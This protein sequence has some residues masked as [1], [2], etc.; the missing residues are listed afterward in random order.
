MYIVYLQCKK[1][2]SLKKNI[3]IEYNKIGARITF[4]SQTLTCLVN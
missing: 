3:F 2:G 1:S 4:M